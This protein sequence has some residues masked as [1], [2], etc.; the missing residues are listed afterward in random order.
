MGR[1]SSIVATAI[2][3]YK[4]IYF[5]KCEQQVNGCSWHPDTA[6]AREIADSVVARIKRITGWDTATVFV[7]Q[8]EKSKPA[9]RRVNA[10]RMADRIFLLSA[11]PGMVDFTMLV[12]RPDGKIVQRLQSDM[13]GHCRW[14]TSQLPEGVYIVGAEKTGWVQVLVK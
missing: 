4:D 1:P 6:D 7:G 9:Q 12:T 2:Q 8:K 10:V 3:R 5:Y 13:S 11:Y 14:N